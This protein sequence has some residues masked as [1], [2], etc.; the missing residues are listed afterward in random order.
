MATF[1]I[2]A[3]YEYEGEVEAENAEEA[4][5]YFLDELDSFYMGTYSYE[6]EE[7][8]SDDDEEDDE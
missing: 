5:Q 4:E 2:K 6:C 7:Q 8:E 3:M 1:Y